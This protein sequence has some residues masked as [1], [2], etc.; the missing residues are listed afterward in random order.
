MKILRSSNF[1]KIFSALIAMVLISFSS[2]SA[3][4]QTLSGN[5]DDI[6]D[7]S[8]I[9]TPSILKFTFDGEGVFSVSPVDATGKEG[10]PYQ[11]DID[12]FSGTYFQ[13]SPSKPIVAL[14]VKGTGDW[15]I[16]I[17]PLKSADKFSPKS[18]S[19]NS[20]NVINLGKPTSGIKRISWTHNGEG[21]FSVSP[22][23]AK[24]KS[25]FPLFLKIGNYKGTVSLPS[26]TQ[27]LEIK[28]D[29]DWTYSIK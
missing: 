26:G 11:L 3:N 28:A 22:I 8:P 29:G 5:A 14:A 13:R 24:G 19:G 15:T 6:V 27:Y 16:S 20:D 25:R 9:K 21:V 10:L 2:A 17:S 1:R 4:P 23:D 18:G 12:S 7:I